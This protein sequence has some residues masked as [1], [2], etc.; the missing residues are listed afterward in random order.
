MLVKIEK[1]AFFRLNLDRLLSNQCQ[2]SD[3]GRKR[4]KK[5]IKCMVHQSSGTF[6]NMKNSSPLLRLR[7]IDNYE[8]KSLTFTTHDMMATFYL[9]FKSHHNI[10][11]MYT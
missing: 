8:I 2:S 7:H 10:L 3:H 4:E 11:K 5:K 6:E 1:V 9:F